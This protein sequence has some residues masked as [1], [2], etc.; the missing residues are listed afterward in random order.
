MAMSGSIQHFLERFEVSDTVPADNWIAL[1]IFQYHKGHQ[2]EMPTMPEGYAFTT[3][4]FKNETLAEV[5]AQLPDVIAEI[6]GKDAC[7]SCEQGNVHDCETCGLKG[8]NDCVCEV[9]G[10]TL[11]YH[12]GIEDFQVCFMC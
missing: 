5:M 10:C 11:V 2:I 3:D 7:E 4:T 9:C 12:H 1:A 8:C 6:A